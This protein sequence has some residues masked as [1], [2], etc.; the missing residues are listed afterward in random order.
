MR[1]QYSNLV[2]ARLY[3]GD[4]GEHGAGSAA[5]LVLGGGDPSHGGEVHGGREGR[6]ETSHRRQQL[7]LG[8]LAV[9]VH[10]VL[11]RM[12]NL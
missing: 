2:H 12:R 6:A 4:R 3:R 10:L 11:R 1:R 8:L 7:P 9:P 5:A